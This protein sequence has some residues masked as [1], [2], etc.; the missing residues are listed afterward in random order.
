MKEAAIEEIQGIYGPV[1]ISE[2]LL[3]KIWLQM[4]FSQH[5]LGTLDNQ[6]L[7][8][9]QPGKWNLLEGPDFKGCLIEIG[10]KRLHGD[11]EMHF[12][13]RDW[14]NHGHNTNPEFDSVILHVVLFEPGIAEP[15]AV[16]SD[17]QIPPTL[18]LLPHLRQDL[19]EYALEEALLSL[20]KRDRVNLFEPL[21]EKSNDEGREYLVEKSRLRWQRKTQSCGRIIA[22]CGWAE[23]CHRSA[24]EVLGYKRNRAPMIDISQKFPLPKMVAAGKSADYYF[25][26]VE[27]GWKT[28]GLRPANHPRLRLRQYLGILKSNPDWPTDLARFGDELKKI[29]SSERSF[30]TA[31]FRRTM[32][33]KNWK[34]RIFNSILCE[35]LSGARLDTL[36]CDAFIPLLA[37]EVGDDLFNWWFHWYPGDFPA[38]L[39][40]LFNQCHVTERNTW[41][42]GNGLKQGA[43]QVCLENLR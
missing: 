10:D 31:Q 11:V 13:Q 12:Y 24:L 17:G 33:M 20:E 37:A 3:Q 15:K 41:P 21:L 8:I 29:A 14:R 6:S 23:A 43:L 5:S 1:S 27:S 2:K 25:D 42:L 36:V 30:Q 34:N 35:N 16:R 40:G 4:D 7:R 32:Q 9:L 22:E 26:R 18:V 28:M 38:S 39:S 19:E